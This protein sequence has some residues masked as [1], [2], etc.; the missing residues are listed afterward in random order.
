MLLLAVTSGCSTPAMQ[1][2]SVSGQRIPT[3]A[4]TS[5][6]RIQAKRLAE[7]RYPHDRIGGPRPAGPGIS[8]ADLDRSPAESGFYDECLRQK[9][10]RLVES[11]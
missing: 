8:M 5:D 9:G 4:E 11:R 7:H 2:Q 6:C 1:W 3:A 10:Y